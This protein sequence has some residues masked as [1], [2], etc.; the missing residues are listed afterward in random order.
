MGLSHMDKIDNLSKLFGS[1]SL[2]RILAFFF[3][4]KNKAYYQREIKLKN[5]PSLQAVQRELNN[6]VELGILRKKETTVHV[7]YEINDDSPYSKP[8]EE[9]Y[10]LII[11]SS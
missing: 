1:V 8:L 5:V 2:A 11:R 7:Y 3:L 10:T 4:N 6:L 9:I